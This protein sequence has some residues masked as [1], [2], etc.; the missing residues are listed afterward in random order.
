MVSV[1]PYKDLSDSLRKFRI[2]VSESI[3]YALEHFPPLDTPEKIF[4][5]LKLRTTYKNDPAGRELFQSLETL[6]DHNKHGIPGAGDCDCFTIAAL[7]TLIAN[8]FT[9]VGIVLAGRN[10]F[11]AKHIYAYV[12][13]KGQRHVFDLTN[14]VYDY[15]R[16]YPYKQS[17]PYKLNQ[18]EKNMILELAD[19]PLSAKKRHGGFP[20][21]PGYKDVSRAATGLTRS[22]LKRVPKGAMRGA[23]RVV[24]RASSHLPGIP[25]NP[26]IHFPKKGIQIRED[27]FDGMS[28]G[29]FQ[30][31]CLSEGIGPD[32]IFELSSRRS[33]RQAYKNQ[34][35]A[36]KLDKM[37]SKNELRRARADKK[38]ASGEA[39]KTRAQAKRDKAN[40]PSAGGGGGFMGFLNKFKK[41]DDSD[42]DS[43]DSGS[44]PDDD[45]SA[46]D[47]GG[48]DDDSSGGDDSMQEDE[49]FL[50]E[51][52]IMGMKIAKA[53]AWTMGITIA[54]AAA[55]HYLK[56]HKR[57][58]AA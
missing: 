13:D 24:N 34:K 21:P 47:D 53:T 49:L 9:D 30:N 56:K 38:R 44:S 8:G 11:C 22:L 31:M 55:G 27:Y 48:G 17:I 32:Q 50:G 1:E 57:R 42:D 28:A 2:Q 10:P 26:Y 18:N 45:S 46:P 16:F 36:L 40:N 52:S 37:A 12:V 33:D 54:G 5:Y 14:K 39:K 15:E 29:E 6:L 7:A 25:N 23:I 41:Q 20:A 58:R 3:P 19:G 43:D 35:R 51:T 4:N